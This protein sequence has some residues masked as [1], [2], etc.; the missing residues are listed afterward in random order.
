MKCHHS[1]Q[2]QNVPEEE[3]VEQGCVHALKCPVCDY[4]M[5]CISGCSLGPKKFEGLS[6]KVLRELDII[7]GGE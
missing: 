3:M 6:Q 4:H 1:G 7:I 5:E 2:Y